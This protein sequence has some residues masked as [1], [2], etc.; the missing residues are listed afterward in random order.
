MTGIEGIDMDINLWIIRIIRVPFPLCTR[1]KV[2]QI[3]FEISVL[4]RKDY[5]GTSKP[6]FAKPMAGKEKA[7]PVN[8][9][10]FLYFNEVFKALNLTYLPRRYVWMEL[11]PFPDGDRE[12]L[13]RLHWAITLSLS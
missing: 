8:Q 1:Q 12:R 4:S 13:S 3:C 6:A 11:A 9:M 7:H 2:I 5:R 10:S